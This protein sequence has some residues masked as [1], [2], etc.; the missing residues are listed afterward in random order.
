MPGIVGDPADDPAPLYYLSLAVAVAAFAAVFY[1]G[2]TPFGLTLQGI[3]DD[4]TR[5]RALGYNVALHRTLAFAAGGLIAGVA[6]VLFVWY[7]RR[8]DPGSASLAAVIDVLVVAV[9][10]GLY[11]LQGAWVGALAFVLIDNYSREWTPD[12]GSILG[13]ERFNTLI[14]LI[15]L[16]IILV[17]PGG[18]VGAWEQGRIGSDRGWGSTSRGGPGSRGRPGGTGG[19]GPERWR[20]GSTRCAMRVTPERGGRQCVVKAFGR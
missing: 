17:S 19:G 20:G 14:G 5:M 9:I 1:L 4:P 10:G 13:P 3:R 16:I 12:V 2:R 6:G 11:R 8:I 18:L 7:N 15:F